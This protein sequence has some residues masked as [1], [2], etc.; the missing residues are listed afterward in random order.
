MA[1]KLNA[2]LLIVD[3]RGT[4]LFPD[5][6]TGKYNSIGGIKNIS[7]LNF[8]PKLS[9]LLEKYNSSNSSC[10][11]DPVKYHIINKFDNKK[12]D[13]RIKKITQENHH[14]FSIEIQ[15][16]VQGN[17]INI[18]G[19]EIQKAMS[20]HDQFFIVTNSNGTIVYCTDAVKRILQNK[21]K[22]LKGKKLPDVLDKYIRPGE[23]ENLTAAL[24]DGRTWQADARI[25][26]RKEKFLNFRM[27]P[28]FDNEKRIKNFLVFG[29]DITYLFK[30]RTA[31]ERVAKL[32]KA[33]IDNIPG[34]VA[35]FRDRDDSIILGEA[36]TKFFEIF[37]IQKRF[38]LNSDINSIFKT[39]FLK[40]LRKTIDTAYVKG[41]AYFEYTDEKEDVLHY[42][43]KIVC[44][45]DIIENG[46]FYILNMRDMTNILE[47]EKQ[48]KSDYEKE[49][50]LSR[51][52]TSFLL[53]MALEIRTPYNSIMAYSNLVDQYLKEENYDSIKELLDSTKDILKRVFK[54]FNNVTE[55]AQIE[56]GDVH[57]KYDIL[58][59]NEVV[60]IAY[61]KMKEEVLG[62]NLDFEVEINPEKLIIKADWAKI[63]QAIILLLDN[64]IKYSSSGKITLATSKK[65][66]F[67]EITI[68]DTGKGISE[69]DLIHLT[70]AFNVEEDETGRLHG[71][72]LGLTIAYN[73]TVLMG[74]TFNIQSKSKKGTKITLSFPL[75]EE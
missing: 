47:Y 67:A 19:D 52:K 48:L 22:I 73:Y 4:I 33:V 15:P 75:I 69:E 53:N 7:E 8:E 12:Y 13:A 30:E 45:K 27:I 25:N 34:L 59:C 21:I 28:V 55:V 3:S 61:V 70:E 49:N 57:L 50:Y 18:S 11:A 58:N 62:K 43:G 41:A 2:A 29:D 63:E 1:V 65:N 26:A 46:R 32:T 16:F 38:S 40:L 35:V 31:Y 36:N 20:T 42:G 64:S 9:H 68:L 72:G 10:I 74:G 24:F 54:L 23:K 56:S 60:R 44:I 71:A 39:D 14:I 17:E 51:L 5:S 37:N 6:K 66:D